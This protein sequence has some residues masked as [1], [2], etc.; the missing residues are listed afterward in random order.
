MLMVRLVLIATV[1]LVPVIS[2]GETNFDVVKVADGVYAVLRKE[3]PG[4]TVNGNS[5]LIINEKDVVVV[6]R[7]VG[8]RDD[9]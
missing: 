4:L 2:S 9:D 8:R 3:S 1:L 7:A 5:V 6:Q